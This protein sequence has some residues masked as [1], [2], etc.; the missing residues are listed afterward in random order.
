MSKETSRDFCQS[1][2]IRELHRKA[3]SLL[4]IIL[5]FP[6]L[7]FCPEGQACGQTESEIKEQISQGK[8]Q[9]DVFWHH[10]GSI[11]EAIPEKYEK[12]YQ[13]W[14]KEF[15]ST[16]M[17]HEQWSSYFNNKDFT[18]RIT[19]SAKKKGG[20]EVTDYEWN[21]NGKLIAATIILGHELDAWYPSPNNYPVTSSLAFSERQ[22]NYFPYISGNILAA[23]KIAHE[24]GHVIYMMQADGILAQR[25]KNLTPVYQQIFKSNGGDISDP[26]LLELAGKMGGT[27]LEI[28]Q[29]QEHWAETNALRFLKEKLPKSKTYR[30]VFR[31]IDKTLNLY[32][33]NHIARFQ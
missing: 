17:G 6:V 2:S 24:F 26:R 3:K 20:A 9:P 4:I 18:L 28:G 13:R 14:K 25:R 32:A 30:V 27:P 31:T 10:S 22:E 19:I 11:L 21:A 5:F 16:M 1:N 8:Y 7:M 15:L 33:G 29:D 12:R 23:T